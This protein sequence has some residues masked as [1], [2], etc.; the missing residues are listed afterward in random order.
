MLAAALLEFSLLTYFVIA[1]TIFTLLQCIPIG[2][3]LR[4]FICG[5]IACWQSWQYIL[6][7]MALFYVLPFPIMLWM[8][9]NWIY[10]EKQSLFKKQLLLGCLLPLPMVLTWTIAKLSGRWKNYGGNSK[11]DAEFYLM[12]RKEYKEKR[13]NISDNPVIR[14]LC[15]PFK[16]NASYWESVLIGRRL[17]IISLATFIVDPFAKYLCITIVNEN[18]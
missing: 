11:N 16:L 1:S 8:V 14:V 10:M 12:S 15:G 9:V 18:I 5:D 2:D 4:L 17:I 7:A 6:F 13:S 3:E